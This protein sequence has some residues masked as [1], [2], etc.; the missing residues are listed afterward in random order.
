ML[1]TID[2]RLEMRKWLQKLLV[3][4]LRE[5]DTLRHLFTLGHDSRM[6]RGLEPAFP[7]LVVA[8]VVGTAIALAIEM[9][10]HHAKGI[11]IIRISPY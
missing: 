2:D 6:S 8:D 1:A 4:R 5:R 7:Q 3:P 10:C 11:L 9:Y